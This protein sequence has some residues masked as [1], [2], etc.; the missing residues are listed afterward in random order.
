MYGSE[1][2]G[3]FLDVRQDGIY[4]VFKNAV[5]KDPNIVKNP[6]SLFELTGIENVDQFALQETVTSAEEN[7]ERKITDSTKIDVKNESL[8]VEVSKD[9]ME[10]KIGFIPGN[11]WFGT[12]L[13]VMDIVNAI[14]NAG[15]VHGILSDVINMVQVNRPPTGAMVQ[16]AVGREPIAGQN[17]YLKFGFDKDGVSAKPKLLENGSVDY[18][19]VDSILKAKKGEPLVEVIDATLGVD[20]INVKGQRVPFKPGKI[21][22]RL[23][24]GKNT[25]VSIDEKTLT[26]DIDGQIQVNN[27]RVDV[28]A[29]L[30]I[31]GDV[32]FQ[33]GNIDFTGSVFIEGTVFNGFTV[34]AT[35]NIE[36]KG[37][38]EG[39]DI[40]AGG[41]INLLG[42]VKGV[43]KSVIKAGG[44]IFARYVERA[45]LI[46]LGDITSES[47]MHSDIECDGHLIVD[48]KKGLLVGGKI[49]A[50]KSVTAKVI[51][52]VMGTLTEITVGTSPEFIN[53][54][55]ELEE[56]YKKVKEDYEKECLVEAYKAANEDLKLRSLHARINLR[57]EMDKTQ[58]EMN[59]LLVKLNSK[60]GMV[61]ASQ[62]IYSGC[63]I[64][65][66]GVLLKVKDEI[67]ACTLRNVDDKVSIG[68]YITY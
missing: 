4:L 56:K 66:G 34:K 39:A 38:I 17:G 15:V 43:G 57:V 42:G 41:N 1:E 31:N 18:R 64:I 7:I 52:S 35:E 16:V 60:E 46:A 50:G 28:V 26:A 53:K 20:G 58:K 13:S 11:Q 8:I 10:C 29:S 49:Y 62:T 6:M 47:I 21:A 19:N 27:A 44:D 24:K 54:Y 25:T 32:N 37:A 65:V 45:T 67:I 5:V 9:A 36:V 51:G 68:A 33:T 14:K 55:N 12:K 61:R 40:D 22:P 48:G 30:H 3:V 23:P 63:R 59:A 2:N